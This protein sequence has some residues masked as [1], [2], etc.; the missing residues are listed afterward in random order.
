M[1][2]GLE[3]AGK[4]FAPGGLCLLLRCA[5]VAR[6]LGRL[7]A[8]LECSL[9]LARDDGRWRGWRH[10]RWRT[11]LTLLALRYCE[12]L[13][14]SLVEASELLDELRILVEKLCE[15]QTLLGILLSQRF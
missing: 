13:A 15:L 1:L 14:D 9:L 4:W 7:G 6:F 5:V 3:V 11:R 12:K 10:C 8:I 2:L